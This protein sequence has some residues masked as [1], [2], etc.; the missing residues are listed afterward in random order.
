MRT[1]RGTVQDSTVERLLARLKPHVV[2]VL[3]ESKIP[4]QDAEDL[5]QETLMALLF[6]WDTI[7]NPAAWVLA[8]LR[9]RCDNYWLLLARVG[10]HQSEG[11]WSEPVLLPPQEG[12]DLRNDFQRVYARLPRPQRL[13]IQLRYRGFRNDEVARQ[14]GLEPESARQLTNLTLA[15]LT[16]ELHL[17]GLTF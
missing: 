15:A 3:G 12:A 5:L 8:T 2:R 11:P 16:R 14:L 4:V 17:A 10:D 7:Q 6:K 1:A 9:N 13:V